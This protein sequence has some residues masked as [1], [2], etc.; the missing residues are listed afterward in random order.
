MKSSSLSKQQQKLN[1][2]LNPP[3]SHTQSGLSSQYFQKTPKSISHPARAKP[4]NIK[5]SAIT[6]SYEV[7]GSARNL[8]PLG[9]PTIPRRDNI[10]S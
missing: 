8:N 3:L 9:T 10:Q 6:T 7:K 1:S 4:A 5:K 2:I